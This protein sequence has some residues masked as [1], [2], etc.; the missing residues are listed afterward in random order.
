MKLNEFIKL[1]SALPLDFFM[2]TKDIIPA[3]MLATGDGLGFGGLQYRKSASGYTLVDHY[4]TCVLALMNGAT[5]EQ[6]DAYCMDNLHMSFG[7]L[8]R[9]IQVY[10]QPI[11]A[12]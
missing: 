2:P 5:L 10:G 11:T 12:D 9:F 7:F 6:A 1:R 4:N 3:S 8:F